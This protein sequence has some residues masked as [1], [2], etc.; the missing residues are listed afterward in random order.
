MRGLSMVKRLLALL[1]CFSLGYILTPGNDPT[2]GGLSFLSDR[3]REITGATA[4]NAPGFISPEGLTGAGQI[5]AIADSGL[6]GGNI[7]NLHP[8][9]RSAPGKMPKVV[10]LQPYADRA[11]PDDP[12]GH[13]THMAAVIAG[14]GAASEGRFRGVAPEASLYFQSI[15]NTQ[16]VPAPP[17]NLE[18]LFRPAYSAGA[19]V[20]VNGWGG[21]INAYRAAAAQTDEFV[22]A[23]PDFLVI[24][25]AGN[26]GP[27]RGT[28]TGEGNS[29]NA[30]VVGASQLPRAAF[31]PDAEDTRAIAS[32]S[33]RGPA[34]D[35]RIKPE[36]L[37]PAS[38]VISAKSSLIEGNLP[39][40]PEYTRM[41]GTSVAAAVAGGSALLM[42]EY[43]KTV[44]EVP[45]PSAALLKAA[46][47]N[48][49]RL[50]TEGPSEN[51]FG[52]ID[53]AGTVLALKDHNYLAADEADGVGN[54]QEKTYTFQVNGA[55]GDF[56][57][58]LVWT[59]PAPE[60]GSAQALVNDL[61]LLVRT[62][63]GRVFYGNHFL[64]QNL[65]DKVNNVEQVYLP[66][67]V[68]GE[69]TIQ[70][71]G[72]DINKRATA[73]AGNVLQDF[74]LVYGQA[75]V[76]GVVE[77]IDPGVVKLTSRSSISLTGTPISNLLNGQIAAADAA[78]L[79]SGG[80]AYLT[81]QRLYLI[82]N[83]WRAAGA[84]ALN[85][86]AGTVLAEINPR[87]RLGGYVL[88]ESQATVLLNNQPVPPSR[89]PNGADTRGVINPVDQQVRQVRA[90]YS[91]VEGVLASITEGDGRKQIA[92]LNSNQVYV[93]DEDV[94]YSY[95]D[96]YEGMDLTDQPFGTG[97]LDELQEVLPGM[98]VLLRLSEYTGEVTYIAVKRHVKLGTVR[99]ALVFRSEI[100]LENDSS[101]IL[102]PGAAIMRDRVPAA[103]TEIEE[104][105][106]VTAI[107]LPD[108][109]EAIGLVVHSGV[110]YGKVIDF[111]RKEHSLFLLDT[112][113][114]YYNLAMDQEARIYRWGLQ[115]Q[116]D[117]LSAGSLV[118][119]TTQQ[120]RKTVWRID[121]GENFYK[122]SVFVGYNI[123][124]GVIQ[125]A[126]G[127]EY[128][129]SKN[130]RYYINDYQVMPED[131][132]S[133]SAVA[134]EYATVPSPVGKVLV[135]VAARSVT[136]EPP[137]FMS[138]VYVPGGLLITG[139]TKADNN[140]YVWQEGRRSNLA[141][142]ENNG[143]FVY[144]LEPEAERGYDFSLVSLDPVSGAVSGRRSNLAAV[145]G[146]NADN[147]FP[148]M[149]GT[150]AAQEQIMNKIVPKESAVFDYT[151]VPITRL[152]AVVSLSKAMNWPEY[153]G[154]RLP[155]VDEAEI[156]AAYHPVVAEAYARNVC[157][158][159]EDETFRPNGAITRGEAAV[160]LTAVLADLGLELNQPE[161]PDH[162]TD[163]AA[164][165]TWAKD[166]IDLCTSVGL[167]RGRP[168]GSFG[169]ND[170][171]TCG[172]MN[173]LLERMLTLASRY[174]AR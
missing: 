75:T 139:Q 129:V 92:L 97:A 39:G 58:T 21:A 102:V 126:G 59:D 121:I 136:Q 172:E 27:D 130:T 51:G 137:L 128:Q 114:R 138:L 17:A 61:D 84:R 31:V 132:H 49:S 108:T 38:A 105:D 100:L 99:E 148:S 116:E 48:G 155:Y 19:R 46:L 24:F 55:G 153:T 107:L 134:L 30:L 117:V 71:I 156:P 20:H 95:E 147:R 68:P 94:F 111:V 18:D 141:P 25:G 160:L 23:N 101:I 73:G 96:T 120:D 90:A 35:G 80:Q 122:Q 104:G 16:E 56:K 87:L 78:H 43:F 152:A 150:L 60:T 65:P 162:Y 26:S 167:L 157:N 12:S 29:K 37:A 1:L 151:P 144:Y 85:T 64:G 47:I 143:R 164:I 174:Y 140:V 50:T 41:Q 34:A 32:F 123:S 77:F 161:E 112:L 83:Q 69:Y 15:L 81:A 168:D 14:T 119:V 146:T 10:A 9:L 86:A 166:S 33:S 7:N 2:V 145:T 125:V 163:E 82:T 74:A 124:S 54:R 11:V 91:D 103:L 57:A 93:L 44:G 40:Y 66:N 115:A 89:L 171:L 154:W 149:S 62:P 36:L 13:G 45:F 42:R 106:H 22:R 3:A 109:G 88:P 6:D 8:D 53:L 113:S 4:V 110:F 67:P 135:E 169:V 72:A 142:D 70:I 118:R 159:Y 165:P 76:S 133:G 127:E 170:L 173:I 98:P 79:L 28:V 52:I 131:L 158:G 5:A 63:D